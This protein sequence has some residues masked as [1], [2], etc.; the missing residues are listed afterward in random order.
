MS[1]SNLIKD[2]PTREAIKS[3][4][5]ERRRL[6]RVKPLPQSAS[7]TDVINAINKITNSIKRK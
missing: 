1:S 3:L 6:D 7:L 2:R 5:E 4:E